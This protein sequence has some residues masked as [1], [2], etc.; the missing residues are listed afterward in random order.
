MYKHVPFQN[1]Q[2]NKLMFLSGA[3]DVQ[4]YHTSAILCMLYIFGNN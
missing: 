3:T 1:K 2:D 4:S